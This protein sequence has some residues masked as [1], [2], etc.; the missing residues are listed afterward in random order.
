MA[1]GPTSI[2]IFNSGLGG[3]SVLEAIHRRLP[4]E[5]LVYIADSLY[6][7]YGEKPDE[8]IKNVAESWHNG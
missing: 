4:E 6:A 7:P 3:L 1:N 8:F 5:S 2:G